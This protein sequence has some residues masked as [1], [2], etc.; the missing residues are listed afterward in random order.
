MKW[1]LSLQHFPNSFLVAL[2]IHLAIFAFIGF[3]LPT[4]EIAFGEIDS[5]KN[6]ITFDL[7]S[8]S[9][10]GKSGG[11]KIP[12][13]SSAK[14]ATNNIAQSASH[15]GTSK[16]T[17]SSTSLGT[18]QIG[19]NNNAE[20]NT[21]G[22]GRAL[23]EV[24]GEGIGSGFGSEGRF[25]GAVSN[26][27]EPLYPAIAIKRNLQGTAII[28]INIKGNGEVQSFEM[29]QSTG[30]QILDTAVLDAIKNWKFRAHPKGIGYFVKKTVVFVLR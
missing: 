7:A 1:K 25:Q 6:V 4:Q 28:K 23:G 13:S 3:S 12:K 14:I 26:Y 10:G 18:T 17:D 15:S 2:G 8:M 21:V 24:N 19:A 30:H 16:I 9:F 27:K 20:D 22:N 5:N 29:L 11:G